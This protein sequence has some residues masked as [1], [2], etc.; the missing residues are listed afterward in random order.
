M[1]T[2]GDRLRVTSCDSY[3]LGGIHSVKKPLLILNSIFLCLSETLNGYSEDKNMDWSDVCIAD[4]EVIR[5]SPRIM[6]E[7]C[8]IYIIVTPK[9]QTYHEMKKNAFTNIE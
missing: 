6:L 7:Q 4:A 9:S 3:F 2:P 1:I 5:H 8:W